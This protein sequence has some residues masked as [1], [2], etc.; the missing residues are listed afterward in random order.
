MVPTELQGMH[1]SISKEGIIIV[2]IEILVILPDGIKFVAVA[3]Q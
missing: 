3:A 2:S 1:V